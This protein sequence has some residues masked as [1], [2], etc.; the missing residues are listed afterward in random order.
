MSRLY[1]ILSY[2][3]WIWLAIVMMIVLARWWWV[4]RRARR[5]FDVLDPHEK[6]P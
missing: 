6:Q 1:A 3:G 4:R 5:S 2:L